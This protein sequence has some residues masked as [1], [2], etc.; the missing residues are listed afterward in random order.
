MVNMFFF[1]TF[2]IFICFGDVILLF[3]S[4]ST[5]AF[6]LFIIL[7]VIFCISTFSF[8]GMLIYL[9]PENTLVQS[10]NK[11]ACVSGWDLGGPERATGN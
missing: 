4:L 7:F 10:L 6:R 5:F 9:N 1:F 8:G 3:F 11:L 2:F